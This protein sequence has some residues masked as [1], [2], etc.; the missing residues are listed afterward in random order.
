[1]F[2]VSP[3]DSILC[4]LQVY[5]GA[6]WFADVVKRHTQLEGWLAGSIT[7]PLCVWLPGLF[8]PKA[9]VTA[10]MQTYARAHALPLDVMRFM[11]DVT[12]MSHEDVTEDGGEAKYIYGLMLEGARWDPEINALA[13]SNPNELHPSLPVLRVRPV[14]SEKYSLDGYYHCPV[15][16]NMQR[17]NVYCPI[18]SMFTLKTNEPTSKWVLASVAILLQDELA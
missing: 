2:P 14:V 4:S 17:A 13:D 6:A 15:Y 10:V 12:E 3:L 1:L 8:N 5:T 18:V 9:Y 11:T 7:T 16:V